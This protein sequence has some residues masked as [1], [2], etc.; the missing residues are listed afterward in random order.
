MEGDARLPHMAIKYTQNKANF[1]KCLTA[2]TG[3]SVTVTLLLGFET[4]SQA[5]QAG[6][7]LVMWTRMTLNSWPSCVFTNAGMAGVTP[8]P[9]YALLGCNPG[10]C[11][12]LTGSVPSQPPQQD[13]LGKNCLVTCK[14]YEN[15]D[16]CSQPRCTASPTP[17]AAA[18]SAL[19]PRLS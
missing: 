11:V 16:R 14:L 5:S 15:T 9:I 8:C 1:K 3:W 17:K 19:A 4:S 13:V 2:Y 6:L 12:Y 18:E 7:E 10:L